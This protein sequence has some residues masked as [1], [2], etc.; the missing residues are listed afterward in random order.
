MK[1]IFCMAAILILLPVA[2]FASDW[3]PKTTWSLVS[4]SSENTDKY[5]EK[6]IYFIDGNTT[7]H[8]M[9]RWSPAPADPLPHYVIVDLGGVYNIDAFGYLPR[10]ATNSNG[11]VK[12]YMFYVSMDKENFGTPLSSGTFSTGVTEKVVTFAKP[13]LGRYV[14]FVAVSELKG[15]LDYTSGA[16]LNIKGSISLINI[17]EF[18]ESGVKITLNPSPDS[19]TTGH[20]L[21]WTNESTGKVVKQ[22]LGIQ[23]AYIFAKGVLE[24]ET[25]Y[26]FT[27]TAYGKD[28]TTLLESVHSDPFYLRLLKIPEVILDLQPPV[29]QSITVEK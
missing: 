25:L 1:R 4:F 13:K 28:G 9:S 29:L 14:K 22:D 17:T 5:D 16:E 23:T 24:V 2:L 26:K 7:T 15:S 18:L 20:N 10:Q 8:W 11:Q 6:A 12:D 27:A 3:L 19:R 21:Y